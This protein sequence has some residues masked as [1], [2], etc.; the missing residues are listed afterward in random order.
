M[1]FYTNKH[2]ESVVI[3]KVILILLKDKNKCSS[4]I[5]NTSAVLTVNGS[6]KTTDNRIAIIHWHPRVLPAKLY[7]VVMC[8]KIENP[9]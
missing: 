9:G 5:N 6:Q 3:L 4:I 8:F 7:P 2:I 1:M